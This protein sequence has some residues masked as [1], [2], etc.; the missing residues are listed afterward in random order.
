MITTPSIAD[1]RSW[2]AGHA[3]VGFVPTMGALHEGHAALIRQA[4]AEC[5]AVAVSI[6]VN[7]TQFGPNE[8]LSRYPRTL[9]ADLELC[10]ACGA[11]CVLTPTPET[12]YPDGFA[13]PIVPRGAALP[14][15]GDH[16]PGHFEGVATVVAKLFNIVVPTK[17]YFGRK[18]LQQCAVIKQLV[19]DLNVHT[20]IVVCP[21][22]REESGLALSSRNRYLNPEQRQSASALYHHCQK[23][24][25][26]LVNAQTLLSEAI[27]GAQRNLE[28]LGF[29]F[30]YFAFVN[31]NTFAP[32]QDITPETALIVACKFHG[33]RLIDNYNL[34]DSYQNI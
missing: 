12:I 1:V 10:Q 24:I 28:S 30:D 22:V 4:R 31:E 15:E 17:A 34:L 32:T 21:T 25:T 27:T 7:P 5:E 23:L 14:F 29:S 3:S 20:E 13:T 18:D 26:D 16:R 33:V 6:F 11:D 19:R 8:D 2:R 9:D